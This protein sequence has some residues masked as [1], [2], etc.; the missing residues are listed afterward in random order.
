MAS[1]FKGS[2]WISISD[3][4]AGVMMIFLL[5]AVSYMVVISSTQKELAEQNKELLTLNKQMSDVAKTHKD[6]QTELNKD[7]LKEFSR[8]L[9]Q[10]NAEIDLDNTVRFREPDILFDQGQKVV[11]SRFKEILDDFFPR[12]IK[13]LS[14]SKYKEDIE[15]IRIEGHTSTEWQNA[16]SLEA[17][18]LGNVGLSQ[19][20]ALEV[21][22]YCFENPKINAQK[23]WL[24]SVL[25]ANGLSFAKPLETPELSRRVEFKA[26]TKS[27]QKILKI[28][29][30]QEEL[31]KNEENEPK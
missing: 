26:L 18:Y 15:E 9:E 12:Y 6:L 11:K 30:L 16:K 2:E 19:E 7:L 4:M 24:V 17:R 23:E 27:N 25:R 20:R 28:L 3:M 31:Q 1:D 21:L 22:K 29:K 8:N 5:I 10:W 13:I 14:Q